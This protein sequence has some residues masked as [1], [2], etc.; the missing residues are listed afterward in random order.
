VAYR[1]NIS[2]SAFGQIERNAN[3]A[4]FETLLKIS[5][6]LNVSIIN[7]ISDDEG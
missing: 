3:K 7:L 6:A 4:S 5:D 2:A 1:L